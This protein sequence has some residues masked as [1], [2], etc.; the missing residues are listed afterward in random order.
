MYQNIFCGISLEVLFADLYFADLKCYDDRET[1]FKIY[2]T[3][4]CSHVYNQVFQQELKTLC[5]LHTV[6]SAFT[7]FKFQLFK[8][9]QLNTSLASVLDWTTEFYKWRNSKSEVDTVSE[10][11]NRLIVLFEDLISSEGSEP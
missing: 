9:T 11:I 10:N 1:F 4:V 7:P 3:L 8:Y 2:A 6:R 5:H